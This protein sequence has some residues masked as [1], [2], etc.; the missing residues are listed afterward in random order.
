V[1]LDGEEMAA[2]ADDRDALTFQE[3]SGGVQETG[4]VVDDEAAQHGLR[5]AGRGA[6]AHTG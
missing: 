4:A 1:R 2:D 6:G 3:A 5:I